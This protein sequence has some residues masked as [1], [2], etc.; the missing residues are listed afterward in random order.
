MYRIISLCMMLLLGAAAATAQQSVSDLLGFRMKLKELNGYS[1]RIETLVSSEDTAYQSSR[2]IGYGYTDHSQFIR[3]TVSPGYLQLVCAK[4]ILLVDSARRK[5]RYEDFSGAGLSKERQEQFRQ[6]SD[7]YLDSV[8]RADMKVSR[9]TLKDKTVLYQC[10]Y[11]KGTNPTAMELELRPGIS[12]PKRFTCTYR[13]AV[14][15]GINNTVMIQK[16]SLSQF[17]KRMPDALKQL[18]AASAHWEQYIQKAYS[19]FDLIKNDHK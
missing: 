14:A 18:L 3:W 8:F 2:P 7:A 5:V 11:P 6:Q 15:P 12:I 1:Y 4:G 17:E 9:K 16:V 10:S 13:M 19:S